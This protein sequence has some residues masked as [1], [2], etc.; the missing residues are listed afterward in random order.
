MDVPQLSGKGLDEDIADKAVT[1]P[2]G[3]AVGQGNCQDRKKGRKGFGK[4]IPF[5]ILHN[6]HHQESHNN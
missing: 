2:L 6:R 4:F 1:D 5:D 3:D